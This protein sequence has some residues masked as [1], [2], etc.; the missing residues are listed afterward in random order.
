MNI[1][2][3]KVSLIDVLKGSGMNE[4]SA[5]MI[6]NKLF[7]GSEIDLKTH[8]TEEETLTFAKASF[9]ASEFSR[10]GFEKV[11]NLIE[12]FNNQFMR[13]RTS[14]NRLSRTEF[15]QGVISEIQQKLQEERMKMEKMVR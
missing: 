2:D 13:K 9:F 14:Y 5:R 10:E 8:L 7:E 6:V 1:Q 11:G 4:K 12:N 15:V 3:P